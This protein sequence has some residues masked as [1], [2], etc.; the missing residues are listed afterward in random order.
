[1]ENMVENMD[2][3]KKDKGKNKNAI[4]T[5]IA[6][7]IMIGLGVWYYS[8]WEGSNYFVTQN[9][10]VTAQLY[11]VT[12]TSAGKLVKYTIN[13]G[14]MVTENEVIGR[15]ENGAYIKSPINGQ[16]VKSN[17]TLNQIVSP[18][19]P[20]AVI[21][22]T[23]NIYVGAN[24]EETDIIK[25]KEDQAVT[26]KLDAYPGKKFR[27]H[28]SEI[29]TTTQTA[30]T[31]NA[32]SFSTSGTYTKVTQLIPIKIKIDDDVNLDGLIGT[33]STIKIKIR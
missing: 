6:L 25:I 21:A 4:F 17:A 3:K 29:D 33:N 30:L 32:T 22:D 9:A 12:S 31:G 11:S 13:Q 24:I 28:V 10:K 7:I 18:T 20:V 16:V 15:V 27:A 14:S 19:S 26:V 2:E 23:N 1:M 8:Y 5:I